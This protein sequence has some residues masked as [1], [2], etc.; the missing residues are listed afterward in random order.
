MLPTRLAEVNAL[1]KQ[2]TDAQLEPD[3]EA[4]PEVRRKKPP[5]KGRDIVEVP[6][7]LSQLITAGLA[8]I[9]QLRPARELSQE[10]PEVEIRA[11][12]AKWYRLASYDSAVVSMNDGTS[13][14]LYRRDPQKFRELVEADRASCTS[15]WP[16]SGRSW[17]RSTAPRWTTSPRRRPGRRRSGPGPMRRSR[18]HDRPADPES[19]ADSVA[20]RHDLAHV[21]LVDP[22][23][24]GGLVGV[25]RRRYLLSLMVKRELRARY[26]GSKMGLA[27]SYIN[28]FTRF[29][30]FF[31]VFGI[32]LGRG[33][34]P[35]F[36]IHLFAGMV[37]VNLF[38]E[39]FNSGT[40]SI[41]QN[42]SIVQ[43]MPLP[44]EIFP[45]AS[46][47]VSLYHTGPAAGDPRR[48]LPGHR[49]V[50]AGPGRDWS[51]AL[52]AFAI[53]ILLGTG[54]GLMFSAINVMYRDWTRVVQIF[55]NMLPFSVPMMYPYTLVAQ[56]FAHFP[57]IDHF[58]LFNP[59]ADAVLLM[60]RAFWITTISPADAAEAEHGVRLPARSHRR[61]SR[62]TCSC[63]ALIFIAFVGRVPRRSPSGSSPGWTT[64]SR[65]GSI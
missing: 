24:K 5:R 21:P 27:W 36:A 46:M 58:Y 38:T 28:P 26:I 52:M 1:R 64:R 59:I 18:Q 44:R 7:R 63:A 62:R 22:A 17:P 13:A 48:R 56:R 6:S 57:V 14:A 51:A 2:F 37:V 43:K 9:R 65:T 25:L 53:V 42:K 49:L 11:M 8:P 29:L 23:A 12:D 55:T 50:R 60:Q 10:F 15:G 34:V 61:T 47:L 4:F 19:D 32:I 30:T 3:R 39:S 45:I 31:F 41:M 16:A 35:H 54:M 40:R 20:A 33:Q